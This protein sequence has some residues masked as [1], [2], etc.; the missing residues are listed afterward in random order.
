MKKILLLVLSAVM[1]SCSNEDI[2]YP[3]AP[4][5]STSTS[6]YDYIIVENSSFKLDLSE[7]QALTLGIV[8]EYYKTLDEID[9]QNKKIIESL[10]DT[11]VILQLCSKNEN[12]LMKNNKVIEVKNNLFNTKGIWIPGTARAIANNGGC[13]GFNMAYGS[14]IKYRILVKA[15]ISVDGPWHF[16]FGSQTAYGSSF[17][18]PGWDCYGFSY[19]EDD[20][21]QS[22]EIIDYHP[23]VAPKVIFGFNPDWNCTYH[24][25]GTIILFAH[26]AG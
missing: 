6:I 5:T 20:F 11:S 15:K 19:R 10:K 7:E 9:V 16:T 17:R 8:D 4:L 14:P 21:S 3:E 25:N 2:N 22:Y 23:N 24:K 12:V 13:G 1:L 26:N 18:G